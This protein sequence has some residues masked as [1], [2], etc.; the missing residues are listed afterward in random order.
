L[1]SQSLYFDHD[2]AAH[3]LLGALR[4]RGHDC[5][6]ADEAGMRL[7]T[8]AEQLAFALTQGRIMITANQ[9]DY[10]ALHARWVA[11]GRDHAGIIIAS[12]SLDLRAK[13]RRLRLL[14][15]KVGQEEFV[16]R[17]EYLSWWPQE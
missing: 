4:R 8:D 11:D 15:D 16:S 3:E 5:L 14:F 1:S 9:G 10:A 17:I 13:L 2:S 7:A 6:S 12:Q